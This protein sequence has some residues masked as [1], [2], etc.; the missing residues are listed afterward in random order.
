MDRVS[1]ALFLSLAAHALVILG[2]G[3]TG[4]AEAPQRPAPMIEVTLADR[5]QEETPEDYDFLAEANQDGGGESET[6]EIPERPTEAFMPGV[7]E[8][9]SPLQAAPPPGAEVTPDQR[10][11]IAGADEAVPAQPEPQPRNPEEHG[12][13][14]PVSADRQ[15]AAA[16]ELAAVAERISARYPSKRRINARTRAH[17][18]AE[19]MRQW[20]NHVERIGNLNY[21]RELRA[22]GLSGR[23]ILE[24]TLRP[25]GV[26]HAA[27]VLRSSG[28]PALDQA[29]QRIVDL[30]A[31]FQRVPEAV[32][33]DN[34]LLVI[35]RTWAFENGQRFTSR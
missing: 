28:E 10:E 7:P 9:A 23:V 24:V 2:V 25:D 8:G 33:Q 21:P 19:Y 31:P 16:A 5:P 18:A 20:V 12:T 4:L 1:L 15:V 13:P 17:E 34:D 6:A 14:E 22:R 27:R 35:T 26:V 30:A 29:A 32:L 3:F 11:A